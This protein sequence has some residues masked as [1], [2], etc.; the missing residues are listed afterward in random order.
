MTI[1]LAAVYAPIG[2]QGGLTG[3]LFREF[4]FTLAGAVLVSGVVALT[5]SPMMSSKLLRSGDSEKG[6]AGWINR[7]FEKVRSDVRPNCSSGSLKYR[8]VVFVI[9]I[10]VV[11]LI[12]PFY[13]FS[14]KELAP[15]EDQAVVFGVIQAAPNATLD[16]TNLFAS[17]GL[18]RL[19]LLP[20]EEGRLSDHF[21]HGRLRRHGHQ[22]LE[23]AQEEH[24][25]A[26]GRGEHGPVQDSRA[27][28]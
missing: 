1:T 15:T 11:L 3:A 20:R 23:R 8:P 22:A 18:R 17:R 21:A 2:I 26:P 13:M 12:F 27:S 7:R 25:A 6:F 14:A 19:Q 16:Q 4:A 5:L 10:A 9:W 24:A 28:A